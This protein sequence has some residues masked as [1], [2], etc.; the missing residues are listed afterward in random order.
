MDKVGV[1][2]KGIILV[3]GKDKTNVVLKSLN[4]N[5]G[6]NKSHVPKCPLEKEKAI[7]AAFEHFNM[8]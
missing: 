2:S 8:I 5:L 1:W 6:D 4:Y 7:M 3:C